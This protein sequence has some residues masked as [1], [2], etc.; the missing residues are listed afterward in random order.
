MKLNMNGDHIDI[1]Q[2]T[3]AQTGFVALSYLQA[4]LEETT[5]G[6]FYKR[7]RRIINALR[8]FLIAIHMKD[9]DGVNALIA[10][11]DEKTDTAVIKIDID[12][13]LAAY[14]DVD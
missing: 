13:A 12:G 9:P 14:A 6:N 1:D 10:N 3:A 4:I 8:D 7:K 2:F 5:D 11:I